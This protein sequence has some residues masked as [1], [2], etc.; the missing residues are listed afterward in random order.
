MQPPGSIIWQQ[1]VPGMHVFLNWD[2]VRRHVSLRMLLQ[3]LKALSLV[4]TLMSRAFLM[5]NN[6]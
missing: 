4:L 2:V 1:S 3:T 5:D 6:M